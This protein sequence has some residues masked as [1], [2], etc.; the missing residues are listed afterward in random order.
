MP[1]SKRRKSL[2]RLSVSN[3]Q[4]AI[5]VVG[6]NPSSKESFNHLLDYLIGKEH[7]SVKID[8]K[9]YK[10]TLKRR[11][12][13]RNDEQTLKNRLIKLEYNLQ[14]S[15]QRQNLNHI[16]DSKTDL[17]ELDEENAFQCD[18]GDF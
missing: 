15:P 6:F 2:Q 8:L 3:V 7:S 13:L 9:H 1:V 16:S 12:N 14:F 10:Q 17:R 18:A 4:D 5:S 11:Q